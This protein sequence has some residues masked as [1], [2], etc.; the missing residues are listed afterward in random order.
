M[1]GHESIK[2]KMKTFKLTERPE[3]ALPIGKDGLTKGLVLYRNYCASC[4][5]PDGKGLKNLAPPLLNAEYVS[6]SP[7]KLAALMVYGLGGPIEVNGI[8]YEFANSMPGI[9][10]SKELSSEDIKDIGNYVRNAFTTSPQNLRTNMVDSI[11]GL[12]RPLDKI[13]TVNEL[14]ETY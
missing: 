12:A 11:K 3:V 10:N 9:G 2:E 13:Y 6:G 7:E 14:N 5:G 8:A 1:E 4:H